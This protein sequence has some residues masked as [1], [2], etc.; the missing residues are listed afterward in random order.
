MRAGEIGDEMH[1]ISQGEV[2]ILNPQGERVAGLK[3]GA[4]YGEIAL[5]FK[6]VVLNAPNGFPL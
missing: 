6:G 2:D 1:F 4:F 3:D 5:L